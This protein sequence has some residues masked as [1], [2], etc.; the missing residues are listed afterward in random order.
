MAPKIGVH[1]PMYGTLI[2][3]VRIDPEPDFAYARSVALLAEEMGLHSIW[4]PDHLLNPM[5]GEAARALEAWTVVAA[6]A[7]V[8]R[9]ITL[10]HTTLCQAFRY[11][12]VLAKM[13]AT[14]DDACQGRF[15]CCMGAGWYKR[16]FDAYG[17]PWDDHEG[18]IARGREQMVMLKEAVD[19]VRGHLRGKVP[20]AGALHRGAEAS[21]EAAPAHLVGGRQSSVPRGGGRAGR[22]LAHGGQDARRGGG[23][24]GGHAGSLGREADGARPLLSPHRGRQ[25][26]RGKGPARGVGQRRRKG[27]KI[28]DKGLIGAPETIA[29]KLRG[30]ETAGIDLV[31]LKPAPALEGLAA[32]GESVL[33][34]F[35]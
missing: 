26:R 4:A 34:S 35:R 24:R 32:F 18:L 23:K 9:R 1:L 19:G 21:P 14:L 25:R 17:L 3:G 11:P 7:G 20:P 8:T 16:E 13:I 33:P 29:D 2:H 22:R 31:L 12:A 30:Y 27:E 10:A 6:L 5:R 28:I 15:I